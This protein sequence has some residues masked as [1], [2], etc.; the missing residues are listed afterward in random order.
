MQTTLSIPPID[1][2]IPFVKEDIA[3]SA[4]GVTHMCRVTYNEAQGT[5][6]IASRLNPETQRW[7]PVT[8]TR[9]IGLMV[10]LNDKPESNHN[11]IR[12]S[13]IQK[14]GRAV[15]ADTFYQMEDK[16]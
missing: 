15:W 7:I 16:T 9:R 5:W 3:C 2:V 11:A 1:T 14:S 13:A 8:K 12:I 4:D 6:V 10:F